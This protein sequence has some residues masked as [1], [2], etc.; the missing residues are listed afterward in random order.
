VGYALGV[1]TGD[2]FTD[3]VLLNLDQDKIVAVSKVPTSHDDLS[4]GIFRAIDDVTEEVDTDRIVQ[5]SLSSTLAT[6]TIV[7]G[8][9]RSVG[10][11][12]IGWQP[13]GEEKFPHSKKGYVP[14]KFNA[15]GEEIAELREA[16]AR[17]LVQK[18]QGE[19]AGYAIS[20]YFS[21]RNPS[22][23]DRVAE[24]VSEITD[25]P[26][27]KSHQLSPE[28]G[29]YE[30]AVTTV[31]NVKVIPV[32][33]SFLDGA[34]SALRER[35]I[36]APLLI[37]RSDG[38]LARSEEIKRKPI[39]T[40]FSGPA[41]SVIGARWL[42]G[43]DDG[44]VVDI[45][46]T[47]ADIG[48]LRDGV[49][50][51][52]ETGVQVGKWRTKV[53]SVN[54]RTVGLGGDSLVKKNEGGEFEFGPKTARPLAFA[55]LSEKE[56]ERIEL[57]GEPSFLE[58]RTGDGNGVGAL[59]SPVKSFYE[60]VEDSL[61]NKKVIFDKAREKG[62]I[63]KKHYLSKLERLGFVRRIGITPTD[64][65]HVTGEYSS[66][67]KRFSRTGIQVLAGPKQ[68]NSKKFASR[69]KREFEKRIA[70]EVTK[71]FIFEEYPDADFESSQIWDYCKRDDYRGLPVNF[72]LDLP[73]VG[74]GAPAGAFLPGVASRLGGD[75]I[76]VEN[77][78][79]GNAVGTVTGRVTRRV[80]VLVV[81]NTETDEFFLFAPEG[82][83][84]VDVEDES[85]VMKKAREHAREVARDKVIKAGGDEVELTVDS[86]ELTHGRARIEVIAVGKP[87]LS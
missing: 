6:N 14:G 44:V 4:R 19:V 81:E 9:G 68:G 27:I 46:G 78:E 5:V 26:V 54:L 3:S 74:I 84:V 70:I 83:R 17:K 32:I 30:R 8:R 72:E 36:D 49:P 38:S 33:N 71:K 53:K 65:L 56:L 64:L 37:M 73:L 43:Q 52:D 13:D 77:Y 61:V 57:Y 80:E 1:D 79:V 31:L 62:L 85:I 75:F 7:Q 51:L 35:G 69:V 48:V 21:V 11:L 20:G 87:D 18:W 86:D 45:G 66:G 10:L 63:R 2:T 28:L 41:A 15:R 23:E 50:G 82:R 16:R 58:R 47:T 67:S 39:E 34:E 60:L 55:N 29:F 76:E 25:K 12:T 40:V 24:V 42:S 22:H 59:S